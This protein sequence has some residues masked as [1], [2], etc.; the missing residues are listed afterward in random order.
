VRCREIGAPP[1]TGVSPIGKM[2][3]P[4]LPRFSG[5]GIAVASMCAVLHKYRPV[6]ANEGGQWG[7]DSGDSG[8]WVRSH[9]A[10]ELHVTGAGRPF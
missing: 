1:G 7:K 2:D 10:T 3:P 4:E 5:N 8:G 6:A 9:F